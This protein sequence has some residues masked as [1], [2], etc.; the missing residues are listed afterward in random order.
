MICLS[1]HSKKLRSWKRGVGGYAAT[2]VKHT[3]QTN[4]QFSVSDSDI[5]NKAILTTAAHAE[6]LEMCDCSSFAVS[7]L[8][9]VGGH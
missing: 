2:A 7:T 8:G 9:G 5:A 3:S 1:E 4:L 6:H